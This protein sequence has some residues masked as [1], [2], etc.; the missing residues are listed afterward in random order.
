MDL[1]DPFHHQAAACDALG[2][3]MYAELLGRVAGALDSGG[4]NAAPFAAVL[5]GHE[6]DPGP[7]GLALRLAGSVHRLVLE[8]RAGLLGTYYPS[9]GGCWEPEG[10]WAAFRSLV[11]EQ[12]DAV[13]EWLDRPPQTNEV[14]RSAAL[15]AGLLAITRATPLPIRLVEIGSSGGL[16]L[17]TDRFSFSDDSGRVHGDE[18]SSVQLVGAWAGP[19]PWTDP[20]TPWPTVIERVGSDVRPVDVA[21]TDGRLTL[22]AYVWPDMT[23]RHERLRGAL[24]IAA[25]SPVTVRRQSARQ[26]VESLEPTPGTIT[27]LWHSVM[28]QYLDDAEQHAVLAGLDVLG[29]GTGE[30]API[31]HL[32]LE[33]RRR[34]PGEDRAFWLTVRRWPGG[35]TRFLAESRPHGMPVDWR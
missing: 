21:T 18:C 31:A 1:V 34:T 4:A 2:S 17:L 28:W 3:P 22:T 15:M 6:D 30:E 24:Q 29:A 33:P 27:V 20:R 16:N 35:E 11:V 19:G 14:G 10:G 26:V 13:R 12:P 9:V 8:R 32:S 5:Q 7:S 23:A 25:G